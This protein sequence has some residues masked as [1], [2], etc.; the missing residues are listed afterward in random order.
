MVNDNLENIVVDEIV[1]NALNLL[2]VDYPSLAI[3]LSRTNDFMTIVN[4]K[5]NPFV[6]VDFEK[7]QI[8]NKKDFL[9]HSTK[10]FNEFYYYENKYN[11]GGIN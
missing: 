8:Y 4:Y 6:I 11:V 10:I 7:Q 3:T 2:N 1:Y 5:K 9:E